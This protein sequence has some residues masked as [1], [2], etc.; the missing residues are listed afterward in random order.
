MP[1]DHE[2][3]DAKTEEKMK[4]ISAVLKK[5]MKEQKVSAYAINKKAGL[6]QRTVGSI[7]K[8]RTTPHLKV[9]AKVCYCLDIKM[10][11]LF[12]ECGD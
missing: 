7:L 3:I 6:S 4:K 9:L 11:D 8:N 12:L 10:S 1:T 5:K 2:K